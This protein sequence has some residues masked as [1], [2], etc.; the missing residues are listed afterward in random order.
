MKAKIEQRLVAS[1]CVSGFQ[2]E[3]NEL[4]QKGWLVRPDCLRVS[5]KRDSNWTNSHTMI[6]VV[7]RVVP[8]NENATR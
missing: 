7:E 5:A 4:L 2:N 8:E 1:S 6:A 3:V